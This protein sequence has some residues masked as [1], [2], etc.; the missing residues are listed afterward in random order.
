[1]VVIRGGYDLI[2]AYCG[3]VYTPLVETQIEDRAK[4]HDV[5]AALGS[6]SR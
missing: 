1:M 3:Y 4:F 6:E 2:L 5:P